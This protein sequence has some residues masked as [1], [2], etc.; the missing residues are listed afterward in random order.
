MQVHVTGQRLSPG[1]QHRAHAELSAEAFGVGGERR[2]RRPDGLEQEPVEL[3]RMPL[4]PGVE[5]VRQREDQ[6]VVGHRQHGGAFAFT[7]GLGGLALAARAMAVAAGV[8]QRRGRLAVI[9]LEREPAERRGAAVEDMPADLLL[10]RVQRMRVPIFRQAV[11][12][13]GLERRG[14]AHDGGVRLA[15]RS[16]AP[17]PS[18]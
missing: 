13:D 9:A 2:Q 7:P 10:A 3:A 11:V 16:C 15:M 4:D 8:I 12:H 5:R 1:M 17:R 6:V 14:A 18:R